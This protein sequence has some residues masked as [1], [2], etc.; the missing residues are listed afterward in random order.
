[1]RQDVNTVRIVLLHRFVRTDGKADGHCEEEK[2]ERCVSS[3]RLIKI[4]R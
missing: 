3:E 2:V 4:S 1:M